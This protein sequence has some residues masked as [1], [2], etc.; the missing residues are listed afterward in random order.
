VGGEWALPWKWWIKRY[1]TLH[2]QGDK[3]N[4]FIFAT[5]RGASTWVM[6][7]IATQP[8]IKY[9][10]SPLQIK[11]FRH[12]RS[13]LPPALELLQVPHP[14]R[15]ARLEWYFHQLLENRLGIGTPAPFSRFHRLISRRLVFKIQ[16]CQDLMN[17][18]EERFQVQIVY[19]VRHPLATSVSR[20]WCRLLPLFLANEVYCQRYLTPALRAYGQTILAQGSELQKKVLD[21]CLQN[22]PPLKFLD[23]RRWLCLHYEDLVMDPSGS[24]DKLATGLGLS[25]REKMLR[26]VNAAASSPMPD[27]QTRRSVAQPS[28]R[29]ERSYLVKKW[30]Q[31]VSAAEEA[32]LFEIVQK[33]EIDVYEVGHDMPTHRL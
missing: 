28:G 10:N 29:E 22:L 31:K 18:F 9:V 20:R 26:Q 7:I 16:S 27:A 4:I 15:E 33:F 32:Q 3:P 8:G 13:P 30:R 14:E 1:T 25:D 23:R 5:P 11:H 2:R 21:W 24:I 19:L 6:E 12:P 17:W